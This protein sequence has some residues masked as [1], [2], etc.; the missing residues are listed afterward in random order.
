VPAFLTMMTIPLTFSI[1]NGLA[2]G[3][4]AFTLIKV[5]RGRFRQVN[6]LMYLLTALFLSRFVYLA[7]A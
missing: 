2:I 1:A 6:W 4:T 5:A 7:K 3:F